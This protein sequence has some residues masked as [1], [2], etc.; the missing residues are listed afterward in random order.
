[1]ARDLPRSNLKEC[2][3]FTAK[4]GG[5]CSSA[6]HVVY[7]N[8]LC[9]YPGCGQH[10]Q[11]IDFRLEEYGPVIHD[12]LVRAWWNDTGFAGKCPRC[13]GWIY[14]TIR[15]K[16]AIGTEEADGLPKLPEGWDKT[17]VIL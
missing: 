8:G 4:A 9:P 2:T 7:E 16:R 12:P 5:T 13:G 11:A 14:F 17:A 1:M 6:S 15:E 3:L 10:L